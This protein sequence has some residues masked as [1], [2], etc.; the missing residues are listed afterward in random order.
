MTARKAAILMSAF[1]AFLLLVAAC[2]GGGG[3]GG[4]E[5]GTTAG[6]ISDEQLTQMALSRSEWGDEYAALE[7]LASVLEEREQTAQ[8]VSEDEAQDLERFGELKSY[9][10][11]CRREGAFQEGTG[12]FRVATR[13]HLFKSG[14]GASGYVEDDLADL[15]EEISKERGRTTIHSVDRFAVEGIGDES[16]GLQISMSFLSDYGPSSIYQTMAWFREGRILAFVAIMRLD[17]KDVRAEV[18]ALARKLHGHIRAVLGG[19]VTP[20]AVGTQ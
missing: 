3:G 16:L 7:P 9:E 20:T 12:L 5:D 17:K 4:E 6:D 15:E 11:G 10:D 14:K 13:V 19:Q 1:A 18:S 8:H 2:G